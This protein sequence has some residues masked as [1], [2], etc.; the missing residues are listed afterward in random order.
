MLNGLLPLSSATSQCRLDTDDKP[1]CPS[2]EPEASAS[3]TFQSVL[4]TI[5]TL[6]GAFLWSCF[7]TCG[8]ISQRKQKL[9]RVQVHPTPSLTMLPCLW[10]VLTHTIQLSMWTVG[11]VLASLRMTW[12]Q[13]TSLR[14]ARLQLFRNP[15]VVKPPDPKTKWAK[16]LREFHEREEALSTRRTFLSR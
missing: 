5:S 13:Y 8:P 16:I 1:R 6:L 3:F 12:T 9:V 14:Q 15:K 7:F 10:M 2:D 4:C 11:M